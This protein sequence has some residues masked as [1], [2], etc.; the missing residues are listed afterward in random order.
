[1]EIL[2]KGIDVSRYQNIIDW[3]KVDASGINFALI[4]GG[5]GNDA[6]QK[7]SM[8]DRNVQQAL[9]KGLHVGAYW[10]SYAVS[11]ADAQRE[12]DVF[13]HILQAY[14]GKLTFPVA[15]DF[16]YDS[17]AYFKRIEGRDPTDA[18]ITAF[19][20][21]FLMRLKSYGWFVNLYTNCDYIRSGKFSAALRQ[22]FDVWLADYSGAPDYPCYI[23]QTGD[24]GSIPGISAAVDIDV[25][26]RDY[27][28]MIRAGGY[29]G[30]AKQQSTTVTIDTTMAMTR[31]AGQTYTVKTVSAL[32][33]SLT[34]PTAGVVKITPLQ[35]T[36]N[37]Q[38]FQLTATGKP[39]TG[40]GIFTSVSGEQPVKRFVLNVA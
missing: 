29:N 35:R 30:F 3:A 5:F 2:M 23:Q 25:S 32:P 28:T 8:F 27:P 17:A 12:A 9:A 14:K 19:A 7:D 1:M 6:S 11:T 15:Y 21:A 38:L 34:A 36:G 26:Y 37:V 13:N 20:D 33:V 4:K 16:E 31:K 22:K 10:F 40:T 24:K 18:E 39:G